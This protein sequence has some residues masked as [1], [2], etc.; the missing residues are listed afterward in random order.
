[1]NRHWDKEVMLNNKKYRVGRTHLA[2][3]YIHPWYE[4]VFVVELWEG[5]KQTMIIHESELLDILNK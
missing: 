3:E 4:Q 5:G 1:M 2:N